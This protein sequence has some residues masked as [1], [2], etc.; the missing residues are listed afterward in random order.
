MA[1]SG[2]LLVLDLRKQILDNCDF[3][4]PHDSRVDIIT[5]KEPE[6]GKFRAMV[7]KS[8]G[9]FSSKMKRSVFFSDV[10][11]TV[12]EALE[13]LHAKTAEALNHHILTHGFAPLRDSRRKPRDWDDDGSETASSSSGSDSDDSDD[14]R[15]GSNLSDDGGPPTSKTRRRSKEGSSSSRPRPRSPVRPPGPP[16]PVP[17]PPPTRGPNI[18]PRPPPMGH[19]PGPPGVPLHS[20]MRGI[21]PPKHPL[22][23]GPPPGFR[24]PRLGD[25]LPPSM[26][27][28][29]V[30]IGITWGDHRQQIMVHQVPNRH[31]IITAA[32]RYF[33]SNRDV[34]GA[35]KDGPALGRNMCVLKE[36]VL[37]KGGSGGEERYDMTAYHVD[38][39]S[40]MCDSAADT[41]K[42]IPLFEVTIQSLQGVQV[43]D[44]S[45]GD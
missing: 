20:G 45:D 37:P 35:A 3:M 36:F 1:Q 12:V 25:M 42:K 31:N 27:A 34:F 14:S 30:K 39:L 2:N 10:G 23:S 19:R 43:R 38:D 28:R 24:P 44:C 9:C 33:G 41:C 15:S 4:T 29:D 6:G 17:V 16:V 21:L 18:L 11:T 32:M 13:L 26:R 5:S 8:E 40:E 22:N 7:I